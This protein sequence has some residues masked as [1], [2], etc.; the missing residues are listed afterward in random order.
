MPQLPPTYE[1][2]TLETVGIARW[3]QNEIDGPLKALGQSPCRK[4]ASEL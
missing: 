1:R 3:V 4:Y 2:E